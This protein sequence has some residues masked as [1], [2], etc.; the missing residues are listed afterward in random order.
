MS[1]TFAQPEKSGPAQ[2]A[3]SEGLYSSWH[4]SSLRGSTYNR[5]LSFSRKYIFGS[6]IDLEMTPSEMFSQIYGGIIASKSA[7]KYFRVI[8][9]EQEAII[10]YSPQNLEPHSLPNGCLVH[11]HVQD[12]CE[13]EAV[14]SVCTWR[15]WSHRQQPANSG[16]C[17]RRHLKKE[18]VKTAATSLWWAE[19]SYVLGDIAAG[20]AFESCSW[21]S[22]F[23]H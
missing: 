9:P 20:K 19:C 3:L 10:L 21:T 22:H 5:I 8:S 7:H 2:K 18:P 1:A 15:W 16:W 6:G 14:G 12:G 11:S 13:R 17:L 23:S 4:D